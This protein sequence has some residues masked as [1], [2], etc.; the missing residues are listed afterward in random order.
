VRAASTYIPEMNGVWERWS[1]LCIRGEIKD[2]LDN[3][4]HKRRVL[5]TD[6]ALE[7][8]ES[9]QESIEIARADAA[10]S[11]ERLISRLPNKHRE[12]C[13]KVYRQGMT[14]GQAGLALGYS[15]NHGD[16]IHREAMCILREQLAA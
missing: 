15:A 3:S 9:E 1:G 12:L 16:K 6:G 7:A 11:F 14:A 8:V 2:F 13:L 4:Y 5:W 10:M